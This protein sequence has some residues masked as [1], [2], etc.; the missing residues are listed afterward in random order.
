MT[1]L[2]LQFAYT[3]TDENRAKLSEYKD[4]KQL[5]AYLK[6]QNT[7]ELFA[8]YAEKNGLKRRNLLIQ[9]SHKLLERFVNSRII[10]NMMS[11]E[12]WMQYLNHDDPVVLETLKVFREKRSFP[13][14]PEEQKSAQKKTAQL[15][16]FDYR[17][18][19]LK[20][21]YTACRS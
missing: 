14:P 21:S 11:E 4:Y 5:A 17:G 7:V 2:I 12:A 1:G 19:H 13:Q 3:Y 6:K 15:R 10:Y 16:A 18:T 8:A 20:A 9:K